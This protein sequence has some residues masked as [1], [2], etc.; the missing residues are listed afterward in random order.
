MEAV[1]NFAATNLK[2]VSNPKA[3]TKHENVSAENCYKIGIVFVTG[4]LKFKNF[5]HRSE[6]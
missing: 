1:L 5:V 2:N 4:C 3:K 6:S